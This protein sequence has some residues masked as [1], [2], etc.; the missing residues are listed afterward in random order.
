MTC[1]KH[2][3]EPRPRGGP[4]K[5]AGESDR[6]ESGALERDAGATLN[7]SFTLMNYSQTASAGK[8]RFVRPI[9]AAAASHARAAASSSSPAYSDIVLPRS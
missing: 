1:E 6:E 4:C 5:I 8:L 9:L 3:L 2:C 7:D